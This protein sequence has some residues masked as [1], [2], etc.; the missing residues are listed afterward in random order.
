MKSLKMPESHAM[1]PNVTPL[2]DVVMC[3]IIFYM[4]AARIGVATG[5]VKEMTLPTSL[6]GIKLSDMGNT[7]TLNV[8]APPGNTD[9]PIVSTLNP[10]SGE[11]VEIA[12]RDGAKTP[13][14]DMLKTY[15]AQNAE[16]KVIIRGDENLTYRHLEP[17]LI[18]CAEAQVKNV[19]FATRE[20][21]G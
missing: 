4:L 12:I 7:V 20:P 17:V 21:Q 14:R 18:I 15:R 11:I 10:K 13:L 16:L 2:I 3:L 6:Q 19:N 1:H 5:A 9:M 8:Q